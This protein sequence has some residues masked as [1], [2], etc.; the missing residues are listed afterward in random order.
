MQLKNDRTG[1]T[2]TI[3]KPEQLLKRPVSIKRP[4]LYFL[5]KSIKRPGLSKFQI[6][7]A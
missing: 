1:L 5:K 6:L 7:E 2:N 4:G 3:L